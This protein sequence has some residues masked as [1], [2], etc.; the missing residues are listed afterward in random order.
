MEETVGKF[1]F[2]KLRYMKYL[3]LEILMHIK[4]PKAYEFLYSANKSTRA[5]LEKNAG[6]IK[7]GFIND[8]LI[9]Y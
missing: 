2:S 9:D 1:P 6:M 5:F 4:L 8:G 7:N 3:T